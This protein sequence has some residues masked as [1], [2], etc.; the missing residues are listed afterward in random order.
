MVHEISNSIY[1]SNLGKFENLPWDIIYHICQ[2]NHK[3]LVSKLCDEIHSKDVKSEYKFDIVDF[4]SYRFGPDHDIEID[5]V[6]N[7]KVI[8]NETM[9]ILFFEFLYE[10]RIPLSKKNNIIVINRFLKYL[11]DLYIYKLNCKYRYFK[12]C[13]DAGISFFFHDTYKVYTKIHEFL[14]IH[15]FLINDC[16]IM[17]DDNDIETWLSVDDNCGILEIA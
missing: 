15:D 1:V 9:S 5:D 12:D 11:Y 7:S 10:N 16:E 2:L 13:Y 17:Y 6:Y 4:I 8:Y 14:Q 3:K